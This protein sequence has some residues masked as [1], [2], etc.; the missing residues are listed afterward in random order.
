MLLTSVEPCYRFKEILKKEG[1]LNNYKKEKKFES[2]VEKARRIP[3]NECFHHDNTP[4][5]YCVRS[6]SIHNKKYLVN[7]YCAYFIVCEFPWFIL[8]NIFKHAIKVN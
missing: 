4:Q 7:W 2:S 5:I 1:Y 6:Q 8:G 3:N